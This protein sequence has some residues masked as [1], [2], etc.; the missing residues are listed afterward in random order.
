MKKSELKEIIR[1][2]IQKEIDIKWDPIKKGDKV[3]I[4][5]TNPSFKKYW[6]GTEGIILKV[7]PTS[8][9]VEITKHH[10]YVGRPIK[11]KKD[12]VEKI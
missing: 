7:N 5:V 10:E 11:F 8:Y 6:E 1:E 9:W 12:K 2:E 4:N 3:R